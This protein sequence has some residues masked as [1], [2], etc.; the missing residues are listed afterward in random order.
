MFIFAE[1]ANFRPQTEHLVCIP[2]ASCRVLRT[3]G[4]SVG[5]QMSYD[6]RFPEQD[7]IHALSPALLKI[8]EDG[9]L[10]NLL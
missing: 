5:L 9:G 10:R 3:R 2:D 4:F 8:R 6:G 1:T 7:H